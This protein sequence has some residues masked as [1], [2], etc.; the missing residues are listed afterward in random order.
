MYMASPLLISLRCHYDSVDHIDFYVKHFNEWLEY[1]HLPV[2]NS[3]FGLHKNTGNEHF[4]YHIVSYGNNLSNPIATLKRDFELGKVKISY[5]NRKDSME[6]P[7]TFTKNLYKGRINMS[8]RITSI[9]DMDQAF[10]FLQYPLKEGI[11]CKEY[12]YKLDEF[13]GYEQLKTNAVAEYTHACNAAKQKEKK[14]E[15]A[16][17]EWQQLVEMLD[18]EWPSEFD[19]VF[20][21]ILFHYKTESKKPPTIRY[22]RDCAE[23][24]SFMRGIISINEIINEGKLAFR[25]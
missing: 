24:Y 3:S 10:R 4:H 6:H 12:N 5:K 7:K 16:L 20:R 1:R 23:R 9:S 8:L 21:K 11:T 18:S 25:R 13:G 22:M 19:E 17:S 14:K 2:Q 15:T